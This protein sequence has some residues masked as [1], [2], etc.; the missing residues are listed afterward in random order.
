[1]MDR[2]IEA[3]WYCFPCFSEN[4]FVYVDTIAAGIAAV[5][6]VETMAL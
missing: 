2:M 1:M 4:I 6:A 3:D 5:V